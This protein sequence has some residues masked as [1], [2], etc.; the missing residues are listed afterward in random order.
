M[1]SQERETFRSDVHLL[2]ANA[3]QCRIQR[4]FPN[5]ELGAGRTP[6]LHHVSVLSWFLGYPFQQ[7]ENE[8]LVIH[9]D[10]PAQEGL[11]SLP[12]SVGVFS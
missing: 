8:R 2:A 4:V 7:I 1:L 12:G 5:G 11:C 3:H 9:R 6:P 10:L